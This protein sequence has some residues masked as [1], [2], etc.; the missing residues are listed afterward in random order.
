MQQNQPCFGLEL[1]NHGTM[2]DQSEVKTTIVLKLHHQPIYTI[3]DP[4]QQ[5]LS[6]LCLLLRIT[7][8]LFIFSYVAVLVLGTRTKILLKYYFDGTQNT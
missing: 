4:L 5:H 2:L 8:P 7:I 3:Y 1:V 6:Y